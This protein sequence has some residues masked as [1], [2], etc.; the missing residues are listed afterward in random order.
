[1]TA[2]WVRIGRPGRV[3]R[4]VGVRAQAEHAARRS[5]SSS[6]A[7]HEWTSG[8]FLWMGA[9]SLNEHP[10]AARWLAAADKATP[11]PPWLRPS[12]SCDWR[13]CPA[14]GFIQG[15]NE[16]KERGAGPGGRRCAN[17]SPAPGSR[18][19]ERAGG[20]APGSAWAGSRRCH[21]RV[22][23]VP[24]ARPV[25]AGG[26]SRPDGLVPARWFKFGERWGAPHRV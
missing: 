15:V 25:Q 4:W 12:A 13:A 14:Q 3:P 1:M 24:G 23:L 22:R 17:G 11:T 2:A 8:V 7:F 16:T 18:R 26:S 6:A 10:S 20:A 19:P 9:P 21:H 5:S